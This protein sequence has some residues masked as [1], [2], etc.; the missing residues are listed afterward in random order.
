MNFGYNARSPGWKSMRAHLL[1]RRLQALLEDYAPTEARDGWTPGE[2][3]Y[4]E[5]GGPFGGV[6]I[7]RVTHLSEKDLENLVQ[8]A[9]AVYREV[10]GDAH[11][12]GPERTRAT[13]DDSEK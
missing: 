6:R 8:R 5:T 4:V 12:A 2:R 9:D 1:V 3:P 11:S 10:M 7:R 13:K